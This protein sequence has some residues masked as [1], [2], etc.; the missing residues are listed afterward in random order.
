MWLLDSCCSSSRLHSSGVMCWKM[1]LENCC[2]LT[3]RFNN[4][5]TR[6]TCRWRCLSSTSLPSKPDH[7]CPLAKCVKGIAAARNSTVAWSTRDGTSS[8]SWVAWHRI[9][10]KDMG[11]IGNNGNSREKKRRQ[12]NNLSCYHT[13]AFIFPK[14]AWPI[15]HSCHS[16]QASTQ[17]QLGIIITHSAFCLRRSKYPPFRRWTARTQKG[18]VPLDHIGVDL[19]YSLSAS[20]SDRNHFSPPPPPCRFSAI[21]TGTKSRWLLVPC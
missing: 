2:S 9:I 12:L 6:T 1:T 21:C 15:K 17:P 10:K 19:C 14:S 20:I 18:E 5:S 3:M 13:T 7:N 16:C 4:W 8:Y 11:S